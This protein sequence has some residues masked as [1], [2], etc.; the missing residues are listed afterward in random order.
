[1]NRV[2]LSKVI[3]PPYDVIAADERGAFFDRDPHNAIRFELTRDASEDATANYGWIRETLDV[4]RRSL[5]R[6]R[7]RRSVRSR[8]GGRLPARG[9]LAANGLRLHAVIRLRREGTV[10][11]SIPASAVPQPC[12][13]AAFSIPCMRSVASMNPSMNSRTTSALFF[14]SVMR[15][16]TWPMGM[17][18]SSR[19][20]E[21]GLR[22]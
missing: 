20:R 13:S 18:S 1:M 11:E 3:V 9:E 22:A 8:V 14:S 5:T 7:A 4:W 12:C 15:L 16:T 6:Q 19:A 17:P 21:L 10:P 2:E